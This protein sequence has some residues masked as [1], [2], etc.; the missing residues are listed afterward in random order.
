MAFDIFR[1]PTQN[2]LAAVINGI[3]CCEH[4]PVCGLAN[5][6]KHVTYPWSCFYVLLV[7]VQIIFNL[8]FG[9]TTKY[10]LAS[11]VNKSADAD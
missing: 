1:L 11:V 7:T 4:T 6:L 3:V 10:Q 9:V 2:T 5:F 8:G